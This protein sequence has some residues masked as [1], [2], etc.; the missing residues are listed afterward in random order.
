MKELG[1]ACEIL[2]S[3]PCTFDNMSATL[4]GDT[5]YVLGGYRNGIPSCSM[6]SFCLSNYSGGWTEVFFPGKP[7]VQP[8]CA[9]LFGNLY[10]W[11]GLYPWQGVIGFNRWIMLPAGIWTMAGA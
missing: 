7:R 5:L 8:V 6:F 10:I 4:L 11:G 1:V 2:P 9:S 3:L